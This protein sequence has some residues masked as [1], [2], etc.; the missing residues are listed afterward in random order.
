M[1]TIRSQQINTL[2]QA[3]EDE[4]VRR[5]SSFLRGEF[6][7]AREMPATELELSI[8]NQVTRA[9]SY[10]LDYEDQI[11]TYTLT[12]WQLGE[13]FDTQFPAARHML[14]SLNYT[15]EE[16]TAWLEAWTV[17]MFAELAGE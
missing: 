17:K 10:G 7:E 5:L 2:G 12:A 15:P 4:F 9:G 8:K 1:F 6:P 3:N 14:K 16:K 11:A 13:D